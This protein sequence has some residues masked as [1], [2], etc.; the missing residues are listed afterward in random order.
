[1]KKTLLIIAGCILLLIT[2]ALWA[3]TFI[4]GLS[5]IDYFRDISQVLGLLGFVL[6]FIQIVLSSK[7][8][9][10]EKNI[11]LDTLLVVHR[12]LGIVSFILIAVHPVFLFIQDLVLMGTTSFPPWKLIGVGTFILLLA[13]VVVA[14]WYKKIGLSYEGW[15]NIHRI[16]YGVFALAFLHSIFLGS[17]FAGTTPLRIY[18]YILGVLFLLI[19]ADRKSTRLNSSHYS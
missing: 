11:G 5:F 3:V 15:K 7:I 2:I 10:I 14:L 18:W 8:R 19:I 9:L 13:A 4:P 12:R 6:L 16:N 17:D 1:M